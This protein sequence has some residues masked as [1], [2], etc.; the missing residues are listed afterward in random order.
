MDIV[1]KSYTLITFGRHGVNVNYDKSRV[2]TVYFRI[3]NFEYH[4]MYSI[5]AKSHIRL[6][7]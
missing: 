3:L 1:G 4:F 6:L 2:Q 7:V 5:S